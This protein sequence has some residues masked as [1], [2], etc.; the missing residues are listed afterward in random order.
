MSV[1]PII[2]PL[3]LLFCYAASAQ[4]Y[5]N[6]TPVD[7]KLPRTYSGPLGTVVKR[8]ADNLPKLIHELQQ[9][10]GTYANTDFADLQAKFLEESIP[11]MHNTWRDGTEEMT[12]TICPTAKIYGTPHLLELEILKFIGN[13]QLRVSPI[14][15]VFPKT[16]ARDWLR[17]SAYPAGS[18]LRK[19]QELV[20][21]R[22]EVKRF[23]IVNELKLECS[24]HQSRW[25]PI[26]VWIYSAE[27]TRVEDGAVPAFTKTLR[28]FGVSGYAG[29]VSESGEVLKSIGRP[30]RADVDYYFEPAAATDRNGGK[31]WMEH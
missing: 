31:I 23:S 24:P 28:F 2:I 4:D 7:A 30:L 9:L 18:F 8:N 26:D 17:S 13:K 25:T 20:C 5:R 22:P 27:V 3:I 21:R 14:A 10:G 19:V 11:G 6:D 1:V 16:S 12:F 15:R 29:G